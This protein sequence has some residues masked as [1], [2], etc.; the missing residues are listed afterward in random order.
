MIRD[1]DGAGMASVVGAVVVGGDFQAL[2]IVRSLG[3]RGVRVC[4]VDDEPSI[5]RFSRYCTIAERV[6]DLPDELGA[7]QTLLD[8]GKDSRA[9]G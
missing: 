4:V 9:R 2:G 1:G 5:S 3:R 8:V 6:A 7:I